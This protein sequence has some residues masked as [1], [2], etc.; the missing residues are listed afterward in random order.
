MLLFWQEDEDRGVLGRNG[1]PP[2]SDALGA[3]DLAAVYGF[4]ST[5][6]GE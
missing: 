4:K 5:T 1:L 3:V 2:G 6:H